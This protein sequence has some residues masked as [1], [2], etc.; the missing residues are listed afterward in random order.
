MTAAVMYRVDNLKTELAF[1]EVARRKK[2]FC[3]LFTLPVIYYIALLTNIS[4]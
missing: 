1:Y 3:Q 4:G 2:L